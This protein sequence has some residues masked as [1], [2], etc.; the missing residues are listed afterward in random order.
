MC[1]SVIKHNLMTPWYWYIP[2]MWSCTYP[3]GIWRHHT[4]WAN[5]YCAVWKLGRDVCVSHYGCISKPVWK[6]RDNLTLYV[7][8]LMLY[9]LLQGYYTRVE[10]RHNYKNAKILGTN[11][12]SSDSLFTDLCTSKCDRLIVRSNFSDV[13]KRLVNKTFLNLKLSWMDKSFFH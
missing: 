10:V 12:C 2:S 7:M 13:G 3:C 1:G 8:T 5:T 6:D 4:I 9:M 11:R